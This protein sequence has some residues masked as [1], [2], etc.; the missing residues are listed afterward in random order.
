MDMYMDMT[1][2][3]YMDSPEGRGLEKP[4]AARKQPRAFQGLK[5]SQ[6]AAWRQPKGGQNE[7]RG[8]PE[9]AKRRSRTVF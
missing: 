4:N 8:I 9:A 3:M 1:L 7:P 2:D 6:E 5:S